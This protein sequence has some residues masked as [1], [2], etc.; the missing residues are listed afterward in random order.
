[1]VMLAVPLIVM[2]ELSIVIARYVNPTTEVTA[3][4]LDRADEDEEEDFEPE[5]HEE[6][7]NERDL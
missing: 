3:H 4:N 2:Y 6:N 1:M 7:G 5:P